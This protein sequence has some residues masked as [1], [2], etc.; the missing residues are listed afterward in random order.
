MTYNDFCEAVAGAGWET[1]TTIIFKCEGW[2]K[3]SEA[4]LKP[5]IE[6]IN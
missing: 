5:T 6:E 1:A 4:V 3:A 2:Y